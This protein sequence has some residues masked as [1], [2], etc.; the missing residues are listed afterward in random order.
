MKLIHWLLTTTL[1]CAVSGVGAQ[2]VRLMDGSLDVLKD[3][4]KLN[5]EY[6]YD[7]MTVTTKETPEDEFIKT[8]TAEYNDKE[9]G[10]GTS[11][12]KAWMDDRKAR[13]EP[14]FKES[15]EDVT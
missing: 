12:A 13:F 14:R 4:K 11:W 3:T 2:K 1:A 15:F 8:K 5:V 9:A 10:K 7:G 6:R